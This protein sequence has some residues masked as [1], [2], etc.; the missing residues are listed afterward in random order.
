MR[1]TAAKE[2]LA[3]RLWS[4][5][6]IT[7]EQWKPIRA[8][9]KAVGV[10]ADD[11]IAKTWLGN[12]YLRLR[13]AL[14]LIAEDCDR[15]LHLQK[16]LPTPKKL[17][18]KQASIVE[19]CN[20]LITR[21]SDPDSYNRISSDDPLWLQFPQLVHLAARAKES[22]SA[23]VAELEQCR[24]E[25]TAVGSNRGKSNS[26]AHIQFWKKLT[27]V[28]DDNVSKDVKFRNQHKINF[29]RACSNQFFPEEATDSALSAFVEK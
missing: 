2:E 18:A 19:L 7:D 23:L 20:D 5:A 12:R 28:F 4:R 14:P 10:D 15:S 16:V 3:D 6:P 9:F 22:L 1:T 21:L 17:A 11:V 25:L 27:R 26:T 29:L 24:D 13:K 8:A